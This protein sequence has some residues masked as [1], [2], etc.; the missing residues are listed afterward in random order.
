MEKKKLEETKG[1]EHIKKVRL[2]LVDVNS[3][4]YL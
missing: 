4:P 1:F 3:R 2:E